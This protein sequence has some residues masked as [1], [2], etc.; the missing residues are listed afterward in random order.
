MQ[1][2]GSRVACLPQAG[3]IPCAELGG[4]SVPVELAV[5]FFR[6]KR[7]LD[8]AVVH[9]GQGVVVLAGAGFT[10]RIA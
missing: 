3:M 5:G 6:E 8:G 2:S 1:S 9:V 4:R 10:S 7:M